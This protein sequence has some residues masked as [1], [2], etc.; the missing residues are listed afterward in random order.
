MNRAYI[1]YLGLAGDS[2]MR[3]GRRS[4]WARAGRAAM[5]STPSEAATRE[6]NGRVG[7]MGKATRLGGSGQT[8]P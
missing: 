4:D 2:V 7:F 5:A 1:Q 3:G 8:E 6:R